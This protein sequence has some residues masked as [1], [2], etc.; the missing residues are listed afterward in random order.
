MEVIQQRIELMTI[1]LIVMRSSNGA[2]HIPRKGFVLLSSIQ[3]NSDL[4]TYPPVAAIIK[5]AG[6]LGLTSI[7]VLVL[8]PS[9]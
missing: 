9:G 2:T 6:E 5:S 4:R 1:S 7:Y 3:T 8:L